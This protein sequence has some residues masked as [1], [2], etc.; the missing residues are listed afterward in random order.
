MINLHHLCPQ[1]SLFFCC[2][3][4]HFKVEAYIYDNITQIISCL[5][6]R[7]KDRGGTGMAAPFLLYGATGYVGAE[8]ARMAI[9]HGLK[10]I[11]AGRNAAKIEKLASE[12]RV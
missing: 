11:L 8:A 4:P 7:K 5:Q 6:A 10:P 12:L 2:I 1:V 9:E 3:H